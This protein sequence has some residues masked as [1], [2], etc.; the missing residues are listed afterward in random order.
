MII[1]IV[2]G[3][4]EEFLPHLNEFND[5]NC[6]WVG[7]DRGVF[8]LLERKVKP[9]IAFGDF[10]SVSSLELH[11]IEKQVAHLKRFNP[12]KDETDLELAMNWALGQKPTE[13][14]IFGATGGR[15]DHFFGN[16]QLLIKPVMA[17]LSINLS[18]IDKKNIVF[19]KGPGN[20]SIL[21]DP[22]FKY[23]SFIPVSLHVRDLTLRS[24]K[25]PLNDCHISLGSTLCI[26]NELI[27]DV[28]T[29]SFSEGILIV[30]RSHD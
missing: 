17:N 22:H 29:F 23:I 12:E 25:Y 24:F 5:E 2:A 28:G 10:D 7:V 16:V 6:I 13:I 18:L 15:L 1:N 27:D 14:R 11:E 21:K 4:P 3:G 26:S 19:V 8:Y 20:Y 9:F 30:V